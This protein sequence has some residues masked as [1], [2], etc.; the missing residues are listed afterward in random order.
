MASNGSQEVAITQR[1]RCA[2]LFDPAGHRGAAGFF[3]PPIHRHAQVSCVSYIQRRAICYLGTESLALR[4]FAILAGPAR[5][6]PVVTRKRFVGG[7]D[8]RPT[9]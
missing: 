4:M 3:L 7:E 2:R 6:V 8:V 5:M 9:R 1:R